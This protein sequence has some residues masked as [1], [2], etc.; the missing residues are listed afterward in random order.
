MLVR[1][2]LKVRMSTGLWRLSGQLRIH[3][4]DE[5]LPC[6]GTCVDVCVH[7]RAFMRVH[8][9]AFTRACM[10]VYT[11]V[12]CVFVCAHTRICVC[13]TCVHTC[14][15]CVRCACVRA[16][17]CTCMHMVCA[18]VSMLFCQGNVN[19]IWASL[20]SWWMQQ[21]GSRMSGGDPV[22]H[23]RAGETG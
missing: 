18:W 9:H 1:H 13:V 5:L 22:T 16:C 7:V 20:S 8:T 21:R 11:C 6:M 15:W 17:V 23:A 10:C 14:A 12:W 19:M 3:S 2:R 4:G